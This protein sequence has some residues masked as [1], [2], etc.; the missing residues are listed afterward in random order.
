MSR[1]SYFQKHSKELSTVQESIFAVKILADF[2][3]DSFGPSGM[4]K[5]IVDEKGDLTITRDG[6]TITD[7]VGGGH[8]AVKVI[9]DAVRTQDLES[10]DGA[11][12]IIILTNELLAR[13]EQLLDKGIHPTTIIRGYSKAF[14]AVLNILEQIGIPVDPK[15]NE[16]LKKVALNAL[17]CKLSL[18]ESE[19]LSELVTEAVLHVS[20]MVGEK[21]FVDVKKIV[22]VKKLGGTVS[23]SELVK[24]IVLNKEAAHKEMPKKVEASKIALLKCP[25]EIEK[26]EYDTKIVIE[27]PKQLKDFLEEE[28]SI[29]KRMVEKLLDLGVNVVFS[30][31]GID[32]LAK[33]YLASKGILAAEWMDKADIQN[34]V[35]ATGGKLVADIY[36][37]K[38]DDLGS[39]GIVVEKGFGEERVIV[40]EECKN[41]FSVTILLRGGAQIILDEVERAVRDA[42]YVEK[43]VVENPMILVGGGALEV[44]VSKRIIDRT[45]ASG[46]EQLA[47]NAFA[48]ALEALPSLLAKNL[49][50]DMLAKAA[51]LRLRHGSGEIYA[52][53]D[54]TDG[55]IK[56]LRNLGVYEPYLVKAEAMK[57]AH[58]AATMILRI[59]DIIAAEELGEKAETLEYTRPLK[60]IKTR[61]KEFET[62]LNNISAFKVIADAVKPCFGPRGSSKLLIDNIGEA[63]Y[64]S[65]GKIMLGFMYLQHP[66]AKILVELTEAQ[67]KF[68]G[69]GTKASVILAGEL[70]KNAEE[71]LNQKIHPTVII[72]GFKKATKKALELLNDMALTVDYKNSETMK[73]VA[74]TSIA[75]KI[76]DGKELFAEMAVEA[77][78]SLI[79][80]ENVSDIDIRKVKILKEKGEGL[81]DS[82]LFP[83]VVLEREIISP[84]MPRRVE[85]AR[86]ALLDCW[87]RVSQ[88]NFRR[89]VEIRIDGS[90]AYQAHLESLNELA[91]TLFKK[92]EDAGANVVLCSKIVD[93]LVA[94]FLTESGI[95]T[96]AQLPIMDLKII[97]E[98][99]GGKIVTDL[100]DLREENL[101]K[102]E[103]VEERKIGERELVFVNCSGIKCATAIIR[104]GT[105][106]ILSEAERAFQNTLKV[107]KA[108]I[109]EGKLVAGGGAVEIELDKGIKRYAM[110]FSG[111][112]QLAIEKYAKALETIPKTLAENSGLNPLETLAELRALHEN[113]KN[114][115]I[116]IS[117]K[118]KL[119]NMLD[120]KVLEP[121]S[122]KMQLVKSACEIA[123]TILRIDKV[124]LEKEKKKSDKL[125]KEVKKKE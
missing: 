120:L 93:D 119:N 10:G 67:S 116:G 36:D 122:I 61:K 62:I 9:M 59:D 12:T 32:D 51:E 7:K 90:E 86:I 57:S 76:V 44:E 8:P 2:I 79:D 35:A 112:E 13:A 49:G 72:T 52:G 88:Q 97:S 24:G 68:V 101:G 63:K 111:K 98:A 109:T 102:V 41:P 113:S 26:G 58:E 117:D 106:D 110:N 125:E 28:E 45:L 114:T 43:D 108:V 16:T 73:N 70:L 78:N 107:L 38:Q 100:S 1:D 99:T 29:I 89:D 118:G 21:Y 75:G 20:K 53:I 34:A 104:G 60:E 77:I 71:L 30:E 80:K 48:E 4:S 6:F 83:G 25:L 124:I 31:K 14:K 65:D 55:E 66:A 56:N 54:V 5:L 50:L 81:K 37:I 115:W 84:K 17:R 39:A 33:Y 64:T 74:L 42:I 18:E 82:V 22:I 95:L 15:D 105:E 123:E 11:K 87:L 3:K 94:H 69:D 23:E 121:L 91:R 103:I 27:K 96:V 40:V 92:I 47:L 85:P 19:F 46:K